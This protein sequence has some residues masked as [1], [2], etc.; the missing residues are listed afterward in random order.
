M[1]GSCDHAMA[2]RCNDGWCKGSR[3]DSNH[4][5]CRRGCLDY[6]RHNQLLRLRLRWR[7]V[8]L[9]LL[10]LLL[11]AFFQFYGRFIGRLLFQLRRKLEEKYTEQLEQFGLK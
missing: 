11:I 4:F 8:S 3:C 2:L 9:L 5:I 10:L 6:L 7:L 1:A